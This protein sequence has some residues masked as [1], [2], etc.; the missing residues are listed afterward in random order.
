[1]TIINVH[2]VEVELIIYDL[3][4]TLADTLQDLTVA[5]NHAL[6]RVG[7]TFSLD[8]GTVVQYIGDGAREFIQRSL[9]DPSETR[10]EEALR[11]FREYYK[12]HLAVHTK[13]YSGIPAVLDHFARKKNVVLSNKP[14]TF[15][16]SLCKQLGIYER[17]AVVMG[18]NEQF[19]LKPAPDAILAILDMLSVMPHRAVIIG[20]S[21]N[22]V[23][24]GKA[25]GIYTCAVNYGFRAPERLR[26]LEP[27]FQIND[28]LELCRLF[29]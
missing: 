24:A 18:G 11:Y 29:S 20:D 25:A 7:E 15:V 8:T 2:P 21:E 16:V 22:D 9:P 23:L 5:I 17:F 14:E 6:L 12:D 3:D 28:P 10:V 4:G 13:T 19:P 26:Q 1:M 27:D